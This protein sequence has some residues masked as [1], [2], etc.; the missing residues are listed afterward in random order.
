M[1]KPIVVTLTSIPPRFPN[2]LEKFESIK[3]QSKRAAEVVLY[4]PKAYRRFPGA[5]V[6]LPKLPTWVRVVRLE[7]DLGPATKILPATREFYDDNVDLLLCDD[8][9]FQD[10]RWIE[11]FFE[12]RGERPN[13]LICESGWNVDD[14]FGLLRQGAPLPRAVRDPISGRT[15]RY[16]ILRALSLWTIPV[17]RTLFSNSGYVDIFEG[18]GGCLIPPQAFHRDVLSIPE[19]VWTVDDVWLSGMA[20]A[21]N[22][23]IWLN[24]TR[25]VRPKDGEYDRLAALRDFSIEGVG[26]NK[27]DLVCVELLIKRYGIWC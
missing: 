25:I 13:D 20:W 3:A 8:D 23:K 4:I 24:S 26:R 27:A 6:S 16:K 15:L 21:N 2:L 11:R 12:C 7:E 9:R 19:I 10:F 22:Y 17:S 14:R 18:S 5:D 1:S